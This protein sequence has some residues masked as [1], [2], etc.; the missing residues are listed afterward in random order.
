MHTDEFVYLIFCIILTV[1]IIV[2][3]SYMAISTFLDWY[4]CNNKKIKAIKQGFYIHNE[5]MDVYDD[6]ISKGM[7]IEE[8]IKEQE[9]RIKELENVNNK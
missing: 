5:L 3:I 2:T 9:K 7:N 8:T 4:R 6:C 1:V